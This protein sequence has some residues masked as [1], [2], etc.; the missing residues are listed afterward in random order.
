M[1]ISVKTFED[2]TVESDE[3]F[4]IRIRRMQVQGYGWHGA[5]VWGDQSLGDWN[6]KGVKTA[7]IEDATPQEHDSY[8]DEKYGEGYTGTV[9]G[10]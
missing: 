4:N 3:T 10:E 9:F 8:E 1:T 5:R 6:F 7:T 2:D